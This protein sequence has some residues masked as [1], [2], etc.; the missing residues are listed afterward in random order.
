[1]KE[2]AFIAKD[3]TRCPVCLGQRLL[4]R[5]KLSKRFSFF[6]CANCNSFVRTPQ[7]HFSGQD[8]ANLYSDFQDRAK[9]LLFARIA[10][11]R[12]DLVRRYVENGKLLEIGCATG[13]F[14]K[15]ASLC[16]FDVLGIDTSSNYIKFAKEQG[17]NV[18]LGSV[19]DV[20]L[21][22]IKFDAI[23]AFHLLEHLSDPRRFLQSLSRLVKANG[24]IFIITPNLDSFTDRL[25]GWHH[26]KYLQQDHVIIYSKDGMQKFFSDSGFEVSEIY[27]EEY[28]HHLFTSL[29]GLIKYL[30]K[31]KEIN[32]NSNNK[33]NGK[34][35][36]NI[37]NNLKCIVNN[38][39]Y[40]LGYLFFPLSYFYR[41]VIA[42]K[43]K[44]HELVVIAK[45]V[46]K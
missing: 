44:G 9:N 26:P 39:P 43:I 45:Y 13:E 31:R 42:K 29:F 34:K 22:T 28:P 37:K 16:G 15:V 19:E 17:L 7:D 5:K 3:L 6:Q 8:Q 20:Q 4:L 36:L 24:F 23:A 35:G 30:T 40:L 46:G 14:T 27:S 2:D 38:L 41:K 10:K 32:P 33:Y 12:F 1:M 21:G 11:K 25:F 18:K